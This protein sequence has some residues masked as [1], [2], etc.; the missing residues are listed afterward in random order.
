M[1]NLLISIN[2]AFGKGDKMSLNTG[3]P[4]QQL[5]PGLAVLMNTQDK[6]G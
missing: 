2:H 3:I 1:I 6:Q 5:I 4:H